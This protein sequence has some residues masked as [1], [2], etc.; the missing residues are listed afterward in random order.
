MPG[1]FFL[2]D[3]TL[4]HAL[5]RGRAGDNACRR[6]RGKASRVPHIVDFQAIL[7]ASKKPRCAGSGVWV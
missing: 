7:A 4:V 5:L 1:F 3:S 2:H 6:N